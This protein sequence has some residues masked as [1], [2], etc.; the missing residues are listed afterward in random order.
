[1]KVKSLIY[2]AVL[3]ARKL[4]VG[5]GTVVDRCIFDG[6]AC[7]EIIG[8][9]RIRRCLFDGKA[10]I[11]VKRRGGALKLCVFK[12]EVIFEKDPSLKVEP[13]EVVLSTD[14]NYFMKPVKAFAGVRFS[15]C[16]F[17][18]DKRKVVFVQAPSR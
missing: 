3:E 11:E 5:E 17:G 18:E 12:D 15:N 1:V 9:A 7:I 16:R 10:V 6:D 4:V 8:K 13:Y 2:S 14:K